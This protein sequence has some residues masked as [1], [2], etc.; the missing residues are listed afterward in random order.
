MLNARRLASAGLV[1]LT[2]AGA[3]IATAAQANAHDNFGAGLATGLIG[4]ALIG[5][6]VASAP[7]PRVVYDYGPYGPAPAYRTVVTPYYGPHCH[8]ALH[9]N[10][11][12]QVYPVRACRYW[13]G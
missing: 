11:F 13:P 2:I 10:H 6:A 1:A 5:G 3:T 9:E 12:G 4:G 8:T 7:A